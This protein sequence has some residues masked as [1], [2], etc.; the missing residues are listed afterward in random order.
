LLVIGLIAVGANRACV[1]LS[2]V[3]LAT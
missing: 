3:T 2:G 1:T